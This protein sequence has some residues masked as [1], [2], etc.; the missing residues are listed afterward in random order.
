[1]EITYHRE[2]DYLISD[3]KLYRL[4]LICGGLDIIC[5]LCYVVVKGEQS[6]LIALKMP[7]SN[8]EKFKMG[9]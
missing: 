9:D 1:M 7:M 6:S 4:Q 3:L 8:F 2:G 5:A